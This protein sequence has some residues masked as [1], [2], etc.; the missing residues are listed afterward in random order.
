MLI[1]RVHVLLTIRQAQE[2]VRRFLDAQG[3]DWTQID[4]HFYV[5]THLG[6]EIGELARDMIS[7]DFNLSDRK[8]REP[9][10]RKEAIS[11]LEDDLGDVLFH[12]FKLAI[13][14]DIDL[15]K[16]FEEAIIDIRKK[17]GNRPYP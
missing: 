9:I 16:G 10:E 6:E 15:A 1:V 2:E 11:K 8:T 12:L 14:Y 4:N 3:R 5:F 13:A 7:A 17:Y